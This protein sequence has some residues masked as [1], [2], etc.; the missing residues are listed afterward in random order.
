M[1]SVL[2][3]F[4]SLV[5]FGKEKDTRLS[6]LPKGYQ[7]TRLSLLPKGYQALFLAQRIPGSLSCPKDTRFF[8]LPKGYQALSLA[9]TLSLAC[10]FNYAPTHLGSGDKARIEMG[11]FAGTETGTKHFRWTQPAKSC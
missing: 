10:S 4:E 3:S 11:T 9:Q 2:V 1:F 7:D 8:P 5:S 6:L